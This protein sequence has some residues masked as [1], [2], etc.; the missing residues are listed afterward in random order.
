MPSP[1]LEDGWDIDY[2]DLTVQRTVGELHRGPETGSG[3]S[4]KNLHIMLRDYQGDESVLAAAAG[5]GQSRAAQLRRA[6]TRRDLLILAD[7]WRVPYMSQLEWS[8]AIDTH[9]SWFTVAPIA[10][11]YS[12]PYCS[13]PIVIAASLSDVGRFA[14]IALPRPMG[15]LDAS[16]IG[17]GGEPLDGRWDFSEEW[18]PSRTGLMVRPR[19]SPP[20][21]RQTYAEGDGGS[22][23]AYLEFEACK[24]VEAKQLMQAVEEVWGLRRHRQHLTPAAPAHAE[25]PLAPASRLASVETEDEVLVLRLTEA[26][27]G[28]DGEDELAILRFLY[29]S[30]AECDKHM[31]RGLLWRQPIE[32]AAHQVTPSVQSMGGGLSRFLPRSN[33]TPPSP[34]PLF[35]NLLPSSSSHPHL[36]LLHFKGGSGSGDGLR[37]RLCGRHL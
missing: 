34:R 17:G 35:L 20:G 10:R 32:G 9:A 23:T 37:L 29:D 21:T 6:K 25:A 13:K 11:T 15:P 14:Q 5:E 2:D 8:R 16:C 30:S 18:R 3:W 24:L 4:D 36:F 7:S 27:G 19:L 22:G 31:V 1:W 28:D 26:T 12:T 33:S